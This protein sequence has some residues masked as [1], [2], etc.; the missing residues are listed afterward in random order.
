M[1]IEERNSRLRGALKEAISRKTTP[2]E[3]RKELLASGIYTPT[4][5]IKS[6]YNKAESAVG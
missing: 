6:D 4:G 3:A 2:E 1:T 5:K